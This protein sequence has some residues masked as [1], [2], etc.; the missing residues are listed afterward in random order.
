MVLSAII[1]L[2][3]QRRCSYG[4]N[5]EVKFNPPHAVELID[6]SFAAI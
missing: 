3:G 5:T 4:K 2:R 1:S 6:P